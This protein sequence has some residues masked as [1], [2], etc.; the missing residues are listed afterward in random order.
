MIKHKFALVLA[1][2]VLVAFCSCNLDPMP[3]EEAED[4]A[5]TGLLAS[6]TII[7]LYT[8]YD[9]Y[10]GVNLTLDPYTG[11]MNVDMNNAVVEVD[12]SEIDPAKGKTSVTISGNVN[13][14]Y[15]A[16]PDP[17]PCSA[18]IDVSFVCGGEPHDVILKFTQSDASSRKCSLFLVDGVKYDPSALDE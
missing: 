18:S 14:K 4:T 3:T 6:V 13:I 2:L 17:Y 1:L 16:F 15:P 12:L 7:D 5:K 8:T 9:S 10:P 11:I